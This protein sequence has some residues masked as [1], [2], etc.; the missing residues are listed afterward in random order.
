MERTKILYYGFTGNI[1]GI[2]KY[3]INIYRKIDK[4]KYDIKFLIFND[5]IPCFFMMKLKM[6]LYI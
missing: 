3:L 1:G 2:E 6:I 5:E 4:R